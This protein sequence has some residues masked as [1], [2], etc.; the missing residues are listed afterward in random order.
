VDVK[1]HL[2]SGRLVHVLP[3]WRSE[4]AP[5]FALFPSNRQLPNRV[6]VFVDAMADLLARRA[7]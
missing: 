2:R 4:L 6:R 5:V 1:C 3:E 7:G